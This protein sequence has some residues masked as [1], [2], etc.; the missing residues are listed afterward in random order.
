MVLLSP[1]SQQPSNDELHA[2]DPASSLVAL[3]DRIRP[4]YSKTGITGLNEAESTL[5]AL[6][7]FDNEICNGGFGQWLFNTPTELVTITADCLQRIGDKDVLPHLRSLLD[8]LAPGAMELDLRD[9]HNYLQQL[10][11]AFWER[12][13]LADRACGPLERGMI[14]RLWSYA[15]KVATDVRLS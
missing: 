14:E 13:G 6:F 1:M 7:E 10:P 5:L 2:W 15:A 12:V 8:Q 4:R 9:W 3:V 11:E